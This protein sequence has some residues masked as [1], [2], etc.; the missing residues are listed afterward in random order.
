MQWRHGGR[1]LEIVQEGQLAAI[2]AVGIVVVNICV[3]GLA[4]RKV[5]CSQGLN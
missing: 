1:T 4:V 2:D 3:V 5:C